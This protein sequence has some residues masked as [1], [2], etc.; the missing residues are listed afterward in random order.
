MFL[1]SAKLVEDFMIW[2]KLLGDWQQL[3]LKI[4]FDKLGKCGF[5]TDQWSS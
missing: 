5:I 4:Q 3:V 2:S 1:H